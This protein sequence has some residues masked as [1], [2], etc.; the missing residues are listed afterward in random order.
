MLVYSFSLLLLKVYTLTIRLC[1]TSRVLYRCACVSHLELFDWEAYGGRGED[2]QLQWRCHWK[3]HVRCGFLLYIVSS[4]YCQHPFVRSWLHSQIL[5]RQQLSNN[6][7]FLVGSKPFS[8]LLSSERASS[9]DTTCEYTNEFYKHTDTYTMLP[10]QNSAWNLMRSWIWNLTNLKL[11]DEG[12][13]HRISKELDS[14][15]VPITTSTKKGSNML[16]IYIRFW[17]I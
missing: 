16:I 5:G 15:I 13:I 9:F 6:I 3:N 12:D 4:Y 11:D 17:L 7:C 1:G 10:P 8:N 2:R 14:I